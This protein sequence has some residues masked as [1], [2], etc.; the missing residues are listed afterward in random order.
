MIMTLGVLGGIGAL[1]LRLDPGP[2]ADALV[3][4][5]HP[6]YL[7]EVLLL[8]IE[9]K[10]PRHL[11]P[12]DIALAISSNLGSELEGKIVELT[13]EAHHWGIDLRV[14]VC[15]LLSEMGALAAVVAPDDMV[16]R[17]FKERGVTLEHGEADEQPAAG[18]VIQRLT[19]GSAWRAPS[20][21]SA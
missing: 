17:F 4:G 15:G 16:V 19:R 8:A 3:A 1:P 21:T 10:H 5:V 9:G 11:G 18:R 14:G 2:L 20:M 7:P 13:G 12:M 6:A